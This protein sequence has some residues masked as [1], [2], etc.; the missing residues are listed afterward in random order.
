VSGIRCQ[1]RGWGGEEAVLNEDGGVVGFIGSGRA[2]RIGE[3]LGNNGLRFRERVEP[4]EQAFTGLAVIETG[5][6]FLANG[7]GK[8]GDFAG[9]RHKLRK[10]FKVD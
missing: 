1:V 6:E 8:M 7:A 9:F 2:G 3:L 5:V 4:G 10:K